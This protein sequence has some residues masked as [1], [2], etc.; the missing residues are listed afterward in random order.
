MRDLCVCVFLLRENW[1]GFEFNK[2]WLNLVFVPYYTAGGAA[3]D[4]FELTVAQEMV[5][6]EVSALYSS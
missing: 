6:L 2:S 3:P 1:I 4:D 5:N